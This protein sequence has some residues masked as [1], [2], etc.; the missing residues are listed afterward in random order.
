MKKMPM[1]AVWTGEFDFYRRDN[2]AYAEKLK[3]AGKLID[4]SVMPGMSHGYNITFFKTE[5]SK[6]FFEEEKM[7][8]EAHVCN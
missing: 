5:Q 8:F 4:V 6:W 3:K 1:T 7:A 2:V